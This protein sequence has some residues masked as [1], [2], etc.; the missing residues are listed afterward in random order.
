MAQCKRTHMYRITQMTSSKRC[1]R[2]NPLGWLVASPALGGDAPSSSDGPAA[3]AKD[4]APMDARDRLPA[5][6]GEGGSVAASKNASS[7]SPVL[8]AHAPIGLGFRFL[9]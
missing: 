1:L 5:E 2:S 4:S 8:P 9:A 3:L 7:V 6:R